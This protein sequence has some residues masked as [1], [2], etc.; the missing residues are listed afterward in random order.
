[1]PVVSIPN[2]K[3][4]LIDLLEARP[5]LTGVEVELEVGVAA[6]SA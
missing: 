6:F 2:T 3:L 1:M 5:A 4:A